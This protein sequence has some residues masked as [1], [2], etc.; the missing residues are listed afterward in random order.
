MRSSI[1]LDF[2]TSWDPPGAIFI[3]SLAFCPTVSLPLSHFY[4]SRIVLRFVLHSTL[5]IHHKTELHS[6]E[7]RKSTFT[8]ALSSLVFHFFPKFSPCFSRNTPSN[9]LFALRIGPAL[10]QEPKLHPLPNV[11]NV[12]NALN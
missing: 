5:R 3:V 7:R 2:A 4:L 12:P 6:P 11:P 9:K 8:N 10:R 1:Y